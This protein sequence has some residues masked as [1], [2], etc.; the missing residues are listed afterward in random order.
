MLKPADVVGDR[1]FVLFQGS[2]D[3]RSFISRS[4]HGKALSTAATRSPSE[5]C[6]IPDRS[7]ISK[8]ERLDGSS[9]H[10]YS[11]SP[12]GALRHDAKPVCPAPPTLSKGCPK[13]SPVDPEALIL[14]T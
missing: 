6:S 3:P 11:Y 14:K 9:S 8:T 13:D 12:R 10:S 4:G 7:K 2:I 5:P 1:C